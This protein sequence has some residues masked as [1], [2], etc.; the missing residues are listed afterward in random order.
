MPDPWSPRVLNEIQL[1][2]DER[3]RT[4]VVTNL[5][6]AGSHRI[7]V[8]VYAADDERLAVTRREQYRPLVEREVHVVVPESGE[9]LVEIQV[10]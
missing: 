8:G 6:S 4:E 10:D 2:L 5:L 1:F 3:D 7:R 9:T